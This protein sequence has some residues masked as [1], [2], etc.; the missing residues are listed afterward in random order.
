MGDWIK[1]I[2]LSPDGSQFAT[3]GPDQ[4]N[5]IEDVMYSCSA[6][7][8][9]NIITQCLEEEKDRKLAQQKKD[10]LKEDKG[11]M[12]LASCSRDKTIMIWALFNGVCIRV[13]KGH[14]TWVRGVN[15]H[16]SGRFLISI[17]DD[18]TIRVWDITKNFRLHIN[19]EDAHESHIL[20]MDWHKAVSSMATGGQLN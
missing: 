17:S 7:C 13:I 3:C 11:G 1:R 2:A 19:H 5:A 9:E 12:F 6:K 4:E 10:E 14:D 8:D 18:K 16:P 20:C 15:F